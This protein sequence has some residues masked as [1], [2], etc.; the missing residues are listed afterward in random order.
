MWNNAEQTLT[1][2]TADE[3]DA[4]F[5]WRE[6][7]GQL[8]G[9]I[10]AYEGHTGTDIKNGLGTDVLASAS[11]TVT[12]AGFD[13]LGDGYYVVIDHQ[14]GKQTKYTHMTEDLEVE[15]G[16]QVNQGEVIGYE[17]DSGNATAAHVHFEISVD[18][19]IIDPLTVLKQ[20]A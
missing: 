3:S 10:N 14:N 15:T 13:N 1:E 7:E 12:D 16:D 17:G 11:G 20:K 6:A 5:I 19:E 18:G 4:E 9:D 2:S 8:T